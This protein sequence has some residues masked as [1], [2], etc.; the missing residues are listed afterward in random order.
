MS[1]GYFEYEN[2]KICEF[3][4]MIERVIVNND[5]Q[6]LDEWGDKVGSHLSIET[7]EEF[8]NACACLRLASIYTRRIDWL[9]SGDDNE[10]NFHIC[11]RANIEEI[12]SNNLNI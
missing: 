7:I 1:G 11:L 9:L 10:E 2:Y 6:T 3:A 4:D 8:Q 5:N 12:N